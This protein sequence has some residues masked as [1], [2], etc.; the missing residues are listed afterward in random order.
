[1]GPRKSRWDLDAP[2]TVDFAFVTLGSHRS[3]HLSLGETNAVHSPNVNNKQLEGSHVSRWKNNFN[4]LN[5][6]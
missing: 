2:Y 4:N 5:I 6:P 3:P 1:M